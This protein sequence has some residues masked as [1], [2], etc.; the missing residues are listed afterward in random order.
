[1]ISPPSVK[2]SICQVHLVC[3]ERQLRA[4]LT[5]VHL[6]NFVALNWLYWDRHTATC[7]Y[8]INASNQ[9]CLA[10]K[11]R[12]CPTVAFGQLARL[13]YALFSQWCNLE[14]VNAVIAIQSQHRV[15]PIC[16][17]H[18]RND[19]CGHRSVLSHTKVTANC[20]IQ[21]DKWPGATKFAPIF[22]LLVNMSQWKS[23]RMN[24]AFY[25]GRDVST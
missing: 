4:R 5:D 6:W 3:N 7:L 11:S 24:Y 15:V 13:T 2:H 18:P 1:M 14:D 25:I 19:D 23:I 8:M 16:K 20:T 12:P 17:M 10:F 22:S 9:H 21:T